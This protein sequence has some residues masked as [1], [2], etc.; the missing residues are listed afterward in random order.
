MNK[1]VSGERSEGNG[2]EWNEG[3]ISEHTHTHTYTHIHDEI[4]EERQFNRFQMVI[5]YVD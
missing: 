2:L 5:T 3:E 4:R 1:G